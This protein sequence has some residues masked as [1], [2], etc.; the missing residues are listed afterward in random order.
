MTIYETTGGRYRFRDFELDPLQLRL[1]R[2]GQVIS[3]EPKV[4]RVLLVL[5]ER[6]GQVVTKAELLDRVWGDAVVGENVVSRAV[7]KLRKLLGED[8][9]GS[10]LVETVHTVGYRFVGTVTR[11]RE[12]GIAVLPFVNLSQGAGNDYF[13]DGMTDSLIAALS[14]IKSLRVISRRSAMLYKDSTLPLAEIGA[15]LNVQAIVEGSVLKSGNRVRIT[16]QVITLEPESQVWGGTFD[17]DAGDVLQLLDEVAGTVARKVRGALAPE[18]SQRLAQRRKVNP[19]ALDYCLKGRYYWYGMGSP[20][21]ELALDYFERAVSVDPENAIAHTGVADLWGSSGVWGV[22]PPD[23]ALR[24]GLPALQKALAID[25]GLAE[26]QDVAARFA[27]YYQHDWEAADASHQ[28]AVALRPSYAEGHLFYSI[29]LAIVDRRE[30]ADA[31]LRHALALDPHNP[32]ARAAQCWMFMAD[33]LADRTIDLVQQQTGTDSSQVALPPLW[34]AYEQ[35]G[36]F[37]EATA[38]ARRFLGGLGHRELVPHLQVTDA[39]ESAYRRLMHGVSDALIERAS[40]DFIQ[41]MQVARVLL[42]A[43]RV[44]DAFDWLDQALDRD[45]PFIVLLPVDAAW[46]ALHDEPRLRAVLKRIGL[47]A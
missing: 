9:D 2:S 47:K 5:L 38:V 1:T 31:R 16:A 24:M 15:Q 10:G 36:M 8:P 11:D 42:A 43:G 39:Q 26:T 3:I 46:R 41:P 17:G 23:Q 44:A 45:D 30:E 32:V 33:G 21:L 13:S 20:D 35:L 28:R 34:S 37:R 6:P 19:E 40:S 25:D 7:A 29:F 27:T 18:E 12:C 4:F 14:G 22:V